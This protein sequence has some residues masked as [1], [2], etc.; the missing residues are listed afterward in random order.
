MVALTKTK[1]EALALQLT[2]FT[3]DGSKIVRLTAYKT[4]P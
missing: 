3:K 2:A 4:I 1:K